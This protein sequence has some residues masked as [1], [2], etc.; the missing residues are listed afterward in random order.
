M[1]DV[2]TGFGFDIHRLVEGRYLLLGRVRVPAERMIDAHSDG[3]I[4]L[5]AL[6][7]A[8]FSAIGK[9]DI[10]TYYPD[11]AKETED[12]DS[13]IMTQDALDQ[14]EALGYRLSNLV[15]DIVLE[16]PKL[17]EYKKE[18]VR[19]LAGIVGIEEHRIAVHANTSERLGPVG[20][21]KAIECFCIVT[22]IKEIG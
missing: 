4:V 12:M 14:V 15:V 22:L 1:T 16:Q 18:I 6:S 13:T 20:E 19:S 10:G 17:G 3:D 8:L 11:K 9:A 5:H 7:Q 21:G 2:R